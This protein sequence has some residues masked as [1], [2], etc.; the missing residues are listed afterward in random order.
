MKLRVE[1]EHS[2]VVPPRAWDQVKRAIVAQADLY[3]IHIEFPGDTN[4][5]EELHQRWWQQERPA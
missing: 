4:T 1:L 2:E 5:V 3:G